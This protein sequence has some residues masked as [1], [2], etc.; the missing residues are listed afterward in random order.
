MAACRPDKGAELEALRALHR[1]L[2]RTRL[3]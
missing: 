1:V 3:S 2:Q